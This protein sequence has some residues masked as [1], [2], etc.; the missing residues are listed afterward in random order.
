MRDRLEFQKPS[1]IEAVLEKGDCQESAAGKAAER[2]RREDAQPKPHI[3]HV[4]IGPGYPAN[5]T[6]PVDHREKRDSRA[7]GRARDAADQKRQSQ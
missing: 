5:D 6:Q 2:G 3:E 7:T 4:I 1:A